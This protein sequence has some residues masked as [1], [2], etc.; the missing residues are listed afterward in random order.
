MKTRLL[1]LIF[2]LGCVAVFPNFGM[3]PGFYR[4]PSQPPP[5]IPQ[6]QSHSFIDQIKQYNN[7]EDSLDA[8]MAQNYLSNAPYMEQETE[9]C[10]ALPNRT[11]S[12]PHVFQCDLDEDD[13]SLFIIH[14]A[15]V[16][17]YTGDTRYPVDFTSPIRIFLDVTSRVN[18][19]FD[20]LGVDVSLYKRS[21]GWFGCGW[22]FI[23]SF[24]L[25]NNGDVCEENQ[26]CPLGRGRQVL[27]LPLDPQKLFTRFFRMFHNDMQAYQLVLR[28]RDNSRPF[29]DLFCATIQTRISFDY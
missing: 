28:V 7:V 24:T 11:N 9:D 29:N 1:F 5:P 12:M 26:S 19:R 16:T 23:P 13:N 2:P 4:Q 15:A 3:I 17:N 18:R 8:G 10:T 25:L 27:E 21:T 22:L 6:P 20:N 14:N